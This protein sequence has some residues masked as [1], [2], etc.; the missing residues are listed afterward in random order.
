[1][2]MD[3]PSYL[4]RP[5]TS[6]ETY[7]TLKKIT[8]DRGSYWQIDGDP[9]VIVMAKRLFPASEGKG[10]GIAKF[11]AN[12]RIFA[13]LIW[14]LHR[15]PLKIESKDDFDREYQET[16]LYISMRQTLNANPVQTPP[17]VIPPGSE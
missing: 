3:L 13:D 16:C 5:D 14:F 8:H 1:M 10:P 12:R 15:W 17:D 4:A 11:P 9:Q 6:G 2:K 7:G